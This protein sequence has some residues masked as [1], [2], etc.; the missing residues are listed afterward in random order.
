MSLTL[1]YRAKT[2]VPVEIEGVVPD[3]IRDKSLAEIERIE[4][5]HGNQGCHWPSCSPSPA[6]R[7]TGGLTSRATWP[8]S[9]TSGTG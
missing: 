3:R 7:P 5:Y 1:R 2:S 8:V 6:I 4:I 9:I